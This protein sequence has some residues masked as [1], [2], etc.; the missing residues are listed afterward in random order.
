MRCDHT[1]N[2]APN[3]LQQDIMF[4]DNHHG[5]RIGGPPELD[6]VALRRPQYRSL[7]TVKGAAKEGGFSIRQP[8]HR[9]NDRRPL[10]RLIISA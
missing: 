10:T 9:P 4:S 2:I 6:V 1:F 3:L 7:A 5:R 8:W